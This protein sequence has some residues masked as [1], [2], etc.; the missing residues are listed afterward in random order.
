MRKIISE[1]TSRIQLLE[2]VIE[3]VDKSLARAPHGY[4]RSSKQDGHYYY[5]S[6]QEGSDS[7]SYIP[8]KEIKKA[9]LLAQKEYYL[10]VKKLACNERAFLTSHCSSYPIKQFE[11]AVSELS[12]G[13]Q[14]LVDPLWL[15]DEEY[16]AKWKS[17]KYEKNPFKEDDITEYY[18]CQGE[19]VRSKSEI[20]IANT[21]KQFGVPYY[22]E[23]P[24]NVPDLGLIHPD[25]RV[26]NLRLR[27]EFFWEHEGRMGK[28]DYYEK[29]VHRITAMEKIG[30]YPGQNLI[31]TFESSH[32]PLSQLNIE[33]NIRRYLL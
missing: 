10:I 14:A 17:K 13:K 33:E 4:L 3:T 19:R 20:M 27:Q 32:Y 31:L 30:Y 7:Y 15:S 28:E 5:Y 25:F 22:Y 26:L 18:T 29:A 2:K 8:V 9:K 1:I 24:L 21:L 16:V 12:L 6:I 23:F 11:S